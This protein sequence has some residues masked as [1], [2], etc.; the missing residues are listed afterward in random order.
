MKKNFIKTKNNLVCNNY[1]YLN[2]Y[3]NFIK[4][5]L[6]NILKNTYLSFFQIKYKYIQNRDIILK[7]KS[8]NN[9]YVTN[10]FNSINA[11]T[12]Y[13]PNNYNSVYKLQYN[14]N[15]DSIIK[16]QEIL[17]LN[18]YS[19]LKININKFFEDSYIREKSI[20]NNQYLFH[21]Q[22]FFFNKYLKNMKS[23]YKHKSIPVNTILKENLSIENLSYKFTG[24][25]DKFYKFNADTLVEG[26]LKHVH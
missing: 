15:Y 16:N 19:N 22:N 3:Y 26:K 4:I 20:K 14:F 7:K 2:L 12:D 5:F 24:V 18:K 21:L 9:Y 23:I 25:I 17:Y 8:S 11:N 1:I 13:I 10:L 6:I